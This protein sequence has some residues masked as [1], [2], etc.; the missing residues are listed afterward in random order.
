MNNEYFVIWMAGFYEGEGYCVN[1]I[2]NNN[3]LD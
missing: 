3:K 1:D 2:S